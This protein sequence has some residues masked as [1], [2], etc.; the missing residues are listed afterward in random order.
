VV[1]CRF[2]SV[3][4]AWLQARRKPPFIFQPVASPVSCSSVLARCQ[5]VLF[6][7][8]NIVT[9]HFGQ[10]VRGRAAD[11]AAANNDDTRLPGE[12]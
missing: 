7:Q 9:T 6:Q 3:Q 5:L 4:R 8:D 11:N 12:F 2:T 10:V 1:A